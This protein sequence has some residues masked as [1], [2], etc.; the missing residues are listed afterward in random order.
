MFVTNVRVFD[1]TNITS[2]TSHLTFSRFVFMTSLMESQEFYGFGFYSSRNFFHVKCSIKFS[3]TL[4][5]ISTIL[6]N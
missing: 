2:K 5:S 3:P 4:E 6:L 1:E